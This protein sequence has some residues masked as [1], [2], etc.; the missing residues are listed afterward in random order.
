MPK[1]RFRSLT[2]VWSSKEFLLYLDLRLLSSRTVRL[3]HTLMLFEPSN[4][5]DFVVATIENTSLLYEK[6]LEGR[7]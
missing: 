4:L 6:L 7:S 1:R 5:R 2:K 3:H